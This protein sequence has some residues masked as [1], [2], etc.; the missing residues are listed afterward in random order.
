MRL[1]G[2]ERQRRAFP[3]RTCFNRASVEVNNCSEKTQL[4]LAQN[5]NVVD[6]YMGDRTVEALVAYMDSAVAYKHEEL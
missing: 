6:G 5:G 2:Y 1:L 4:I 3:V